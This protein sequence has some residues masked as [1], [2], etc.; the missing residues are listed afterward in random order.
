MYI[1]TNIKKNTKFL[2]N[3]Q[4]QISKEQPSFNCTIERPN[5]HWKFFQIILCIW[6]YVDPPWNKSKENFFLK[7]CV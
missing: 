2:L 6:F 5:K 1:Q 3:K 4:L 7:S